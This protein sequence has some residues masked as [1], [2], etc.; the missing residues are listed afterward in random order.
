MK[1]ERYAYLIFAI[2]SITVSV[3][4]LGGNYIIHFI[5]IY[6][7]VNAPSSL[8]FTENFFSAWSTENMGGYN[9]LNI[10]NLA[11]YATIAALY[12]LGVPTYLQEI[13]LL[14]LMDFLSMSFYFRIMKE[15]LL[16][17]ENEKHI[18]ISFFSSIILTFNYSM[19]IVIWWDSIPNGFFLIGFGPMFIYYLLRFSKSFLVQGK[20]DLLSASFLFL[21]SALSFSVNIP[22]NMSLIF[23]TLVFVLYSVLF[24]RSAFRTAA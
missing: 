22:F 10:F 2:L 17:N 15:Y 5:D 12:L 18:L 7:P 4:N 3:V 13:F 21:A 23:I 16:N 8:Y 1:F 24:F 11:P 9:I 14:S 6:W 20:F 19:I